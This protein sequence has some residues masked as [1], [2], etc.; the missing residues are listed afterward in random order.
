L[1]P[2][3]SWCPDSRCLLASDSYAEET[4]DAVYVIAVDTGDKRQL[5]HPTDQTADGDAIV[6]ADGR[7]LVF[8]RNTTPFSGAFYR[9]SLAAGMVPQGEP[10]RL[11]PTLNAGKPTWIPASNEILFASRGGLWRLDALRAGT[12]RRLPFVGQDGHSPVVSRTADGRQRLVYGRSFSDSNVW[13]VNTIASGTA[14]PSPAIAFASTRADFLPNL[15][16]DGGHIAFL[17]DRSGDMQIWTADPDGSNARQL[18]SM[19]FSSSPGY[20]RW[21]PDSKTIAFHGDPAGR[22]DI[23]VVPANGGGRPVNL[24]AGGP[25]GGFPSFSRDGRWIYFCSVDNKQPRIWKMPATGGPAVQ[26]TR[27]AATIAIESPD[28]RDLYYVAESDRTSSLWRLPVAGGQP[29]KLLDG[30]LFGNFDVVEGGIYFIDRKSADFAGFLIDRP[31]ETRLQYFD[32]ATTRIST[33][34]RNLGWVG[35]GLSASRDG[36]T[37]FFSRIDSAVDELMVVDDFR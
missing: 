5:T 12:P 15:S 9:L 6:S 29:V 26:V 23:V 2:S 20:P 3:I 21:S 7:S 13:R 34:A 30:V 28:G 32:L 1:P 31:G 17:S 35:L 22:P 18:T 36:R 8:R 19:T 24:T 27:A 11:T 33:V 14:K 16:P 25:N 4:P 10:V 37:V